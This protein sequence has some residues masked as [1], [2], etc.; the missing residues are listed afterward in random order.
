MVFYDVTP[1]TYQYAY[2]IMMPKM[3]RNGQEGF[4]VVESMLFLAI[5]ALLVIS[6]L[7][8]VS[9]SINTQRY[10][11][12]VETFKSFLQDQYGELQH[13]FNGRS[14]EWSCTNK[15]VTV[16]DGISPEERGQSD[17]VV[18]G[19]Y[20][21]IKDDA[22]RTAT[23][24]GYETSAE[25][26][27]DIDTLKMNYE[28]GLSFVDTGEKQ[29]DWGTRIAW[30]T[31]GPEAKAA[32]ASRSLAILMVRSPVSGGVYTF[33]SDTVK[34]LEDT[35]SSDLK[36][37]L[38][39]ADSVPGQAGRTICIAANGLSVSGNTSVYIVA[40]AVN[41]SGIETRSNGILQ[42]LNGAVRC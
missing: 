15:A 37:M 33:T 24:V 30:P 7:A 22:I 10:R 1:V 3:G 41:A 34:K 31:A 29:L 17:C 35:A 9:V 4:T 8:G 36:A 6:L 39:T 14:G 42:Q 21:T 28:L 5:S 16:E 12:S 13:V 32:S 27:N 25:A 23:V 38:V 26:Q 2:A 20:I 11:D 40:H 18:L 19:K